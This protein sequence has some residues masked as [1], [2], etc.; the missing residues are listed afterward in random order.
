METP[1]S[2]IDNDHDVIDE[3]CPIFKSI[4]FKEHGR[5][6]NNQTIQEAKK[7]GKVHIGVSF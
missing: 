6:K 3:Y 2:L 1:G 5:L 7:K 4:T